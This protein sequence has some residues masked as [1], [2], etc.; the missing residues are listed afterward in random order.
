MVNPVTTVDTTLPLGTGVASQSPATDDPE[1]EAD[2]GLR[3]S[4]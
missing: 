1:F 4:V 2:L 3:G